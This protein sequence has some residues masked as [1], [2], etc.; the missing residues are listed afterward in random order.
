MKNY[1][2]MT[3]SVL[4]RVS[5]NNIARK[6]RRTVIMRTA[7]PVCGALAVVGAVTLTQIKS[8][9]PTDSDYIAAGG[10]GYEKG[11]S[12]QVPSPGG[13]TIGATIDE[14]GN[15]SYIYENTENSDTAT[16]D[17]PKSDYDTGKFYSAPED[18]IRGCPS[19]A[20]IRTELSPEEAVKYYGVDIFAPKEFFKDCIVK[21]D[22]FTLSKRDGELVYDGNFVEFEFADSS[23]YILALFRKETKWVPSNV[24][25]SE[26]FG[27][28][29][30]TFFKDGVETRA[31]FEVNGTQ[32]TLLYNGSDMK[33]LLNAIKIYSASGIDGNKTNEPV[34]TAD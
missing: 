8:P 2:E 16:S 27:D 15:V 9:V 6:K 25:E 5:E 33:K 26:D 24:Y 13:N 7:I 32:I 31:V 10:S 12:T 14:N 29:E 21:A 22:T 19:Y 30:V 17:N 18:L 34:L 11:G 4:K 20:N 23:E 3:T 1:E 28:T